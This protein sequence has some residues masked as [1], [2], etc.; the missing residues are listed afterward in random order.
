MTNGRE[1]TRLVLYSRAG[2]ALCDEMA[3]E[4][5]AWLAGRPYSVEV[6]DVDADPVAQARFGLMVPVLLVDSQ[7]A[8]SGR[9]DTDLVDELLTS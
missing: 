7:P 6:R 8:C 3:G 2:C 4:L 9:L 5:A 1:P